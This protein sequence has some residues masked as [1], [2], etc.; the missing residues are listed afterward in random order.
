MIDEI[1]YI[2]GRGGSIHDGLGIFLKERASKVSGISLSVE[3]LSAEFDDQLAAIRSH[4]ERIE[5]FVGCRFVPPYRGNDKND[6]VHG[7]RKV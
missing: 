4:F 3:Y 2:T 7:C 5:R 1:F 6:R